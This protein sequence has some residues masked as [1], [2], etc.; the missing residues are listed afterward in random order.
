MQ[1]RI[2][3]RLIAHTAFT[4]VVKNQ[5]PSC[6]LYARAHS[7]AIGFCSDQKNLQPLVRIPTIVA[8]QLWSLPI[9]VDQDVQIAIVIEV[10]D[11]RTTDDAWQPEIRSKLATYIFENAA[12]CV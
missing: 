12:A 11:R 4:L 10:T 1:A 9:V 6:K 7:V 3:C 8:Q 5:I 2:L